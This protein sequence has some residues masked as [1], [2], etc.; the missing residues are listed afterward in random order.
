MTK[1]ATFDPLEVDLPGELAALPAED[2]AGAP[3]PT[4]CG[5]CGA[6]ASPSFAGLCVVCYD[7]LPHTAGCGL[8]L[9]LVAALAGDFGAP[10][11][12]VAHLTTCPACRGFFGRLAEVVRVADMETPHAAQPASTAA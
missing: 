2:D 9:A 4:P 3:D 1:I 10:A 6:H 8:G 5:R 7:R 11:S 12:A